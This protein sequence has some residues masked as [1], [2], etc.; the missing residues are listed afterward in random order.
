MINTRF[1]SRV[2]FEN[3]ASS[4]Y[5]LFFQGQILWLLTPV[6]FLGSKQSKLFLAIKEKAVNWVNTRNHL[7]AIEPG[8]ENQKDQRKVRKRRT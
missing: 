5:R 7:E 1:C 3:I 6:S 2:F 4:N 8:S